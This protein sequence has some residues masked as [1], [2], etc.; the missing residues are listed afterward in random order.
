[1]IVDLDALRL[2]PICALPGCI[3]FI[4]RIVM[5][6]RL[7]ASSLRGAFGSKRVWFVY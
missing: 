3:N 4:L 5:L 2:Q 6:K 7:Q 1:M